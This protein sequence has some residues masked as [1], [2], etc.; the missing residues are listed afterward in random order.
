MPY[1]AMTAFPSN[2]LSFDFHDRVFNVFSELSLWTLAFVTCADLILTLCFVSS[3]SD[4]KLSS[5]EAVNRVLAGEKGDLKG[6]TSLTSKSQELD[7]KNA[8]EE[9][10]R[11]HKDKEVN[12]KLHIFENEIM[13][14]SIVQVKTF[15]SLTVV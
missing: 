13:S 12:C 6:R 3:D 10:P 7:N 11:G 15:I 5:D 8:R 2:V 9:E 4:H 1:L 14:L